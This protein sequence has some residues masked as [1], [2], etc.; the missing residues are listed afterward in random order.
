M[1]KSYVL[2]GM[3]RYRNRQVIT[4]LIIEER[5]AWQTSS[6]SERA[7]A[8]SQ[9]SRNKFYSWR[10]HTFSQHGQVVGSKSSMLDDKQSE[11]TS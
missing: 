2:C 8:Q 9:M 5:N 10:G 4:F 6:N 7:S 3:E 1:S 11:F